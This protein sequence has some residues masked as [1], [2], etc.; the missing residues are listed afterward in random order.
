MSDYLRITLW[1]GLSFLLFAGSVSAM[2]QNEA[3][4]WRDV[5]RAANLAYI[6]KR[7]G[8]AANLYEAAVKAME[9]SS[10]TPDAI[11]DVLANQSECLVKSG[12][13]AEAARCLA[14]CQELVGLHHLDREPVA[15]RVL[16]RV[17]MLKISRGDN[18]AVCLAIRT[19]RLQ[20]AE[21]LFGEHAELVHSYLYPVVASLFD[22]KR[23]LEVIEIGKRGLKLLEGSKSSSVPAY[24]VELTHPIAMSYLEL[25][26]PDEAKECYQKLISYLRNIPEASDYLQE[27]LVQYQEVERRRST[28]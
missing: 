18:P 3:G 16:N 28:N 8:V 10:Q 22:A 20:L 12:R 14:R 13:F 11:I 1:F 23:Y 25:G 4:D 9:N 15:I 24:L 2:N 27:A 7:Y 19:Q 5:A 6:E 17:D 26:R 21:A